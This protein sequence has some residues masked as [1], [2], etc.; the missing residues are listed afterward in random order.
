MLC[1]FIASGCCSCQTVKLVAIRSMEQQSFRGLS[2][3]DDRVAWIGGTNG[4]VGVSR[5]GGKEWKM[6]QVRGHEEKDFRSIYAF[7]SLT[8]VIANAGS[9][10]YILRTEDGGRN[11][12]TVYFNDHPDAFIDGVDFWN[13]KEGLIYGDPIGGRMLIIRTLDGGRTWKDADEQ[14]RPLLEDGEAS[15]AA[16]GT[17]VRCLKGGRIVVVTGGKV[18]RQFSSVDKGINWSA[19]KT[20]IIQG[21]ST[22][23]IFSIAFSGMN[24]I[25]VGGD[26]KRDSLKTDHVFYSGDGGKT[27]IAP[28]RTTGGYRECVEFITEKIALAVGPGGLD[29]TRDAGVSWSPLSAEKLFHVARKARSGS[30]VVIAGG[31]G[32]VGYFIE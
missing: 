10:A 29:I 8:A 25:I 2:V 28:R 16:S 17:G 30:L 23:G 22:T 31:D 21:E 15:F 1:V 11:W 19:A 3:V 24:G 9:P 20:P 4:W 32:R 5:D 13:E 14:A 18:S 27:W 12:K 6:Q 7:D 26:F